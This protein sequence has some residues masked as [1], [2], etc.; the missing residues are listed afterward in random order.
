MFSVAVC[1]N[2]QAELDLARELACRWLAAQG[3]ARSGAVGFLNP[4]DLARRLR[5]GREADRH[6]RGGRRDRDD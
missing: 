6:D 5:A 2:D 4:E 3:E 1:D